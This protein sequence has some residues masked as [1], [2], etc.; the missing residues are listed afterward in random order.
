MATA[1][2]NTQC[3][4]CPEKTSTFL[5]N[6]CSENFCFN[7]LT[8]HR[9]SLNAQLI[10]IQEDYKLFN[11]IIIDRKNNPEQHPLIK[12]IDQWEK[13]SI[14]KIKQK[15]KEHREII[16]HFT[17]RIINQIEM[18]FNYPNEQLI[19]NQRRNEFNEIDLIKFKQ[20]LEKLKEELNQPMNVSIEQQS[21]SFIN[22]IS[23][24][25]SKFLQFNF[26]STNFVFIL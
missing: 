12:Q 23:I 11:K 19:S 9:Q 1:N 18:K 10:R 6:G 2:L 8:E 5:C 20:K 15:A 13:D 25:F 7:H 26:K 14:E 3:S 24:K 16:I 4:I 22:Q 17:N 21:N